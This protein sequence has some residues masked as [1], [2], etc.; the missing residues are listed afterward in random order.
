MMPVISCSWDLT[1]PEVA[2][3]QKELATQVSTLPL[4]LIWV[5]FHIPAP[6]T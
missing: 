2:T 4:S 5:N 3:L 6:K 1:P